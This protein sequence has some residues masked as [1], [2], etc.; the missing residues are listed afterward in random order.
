MIVIQVAALLC[1][2]IG[3]SEGARFAL[4]EGAKTTSA[5]FSSLT[6]RRCGLGL[7]LNVSDHGGAKELVDS[8]LE[9]RR[10]GCD[11]MPVS[12]KW[13]ELEPTPGRFELDKLKSDLKG[14]AQMG[15]TS[16]LL[17]KTI[18]TSQRTVPTDLANEP[19]DSPRMAEREAAFLRAVRN[20][21]PERVGGIMLGNEVDGYLG[22]RPLEV[23]RYI[24]FLENGRRTL[25]ADRPGLAVGVTTMFTGLKSHPDVIGRL[26]RPMDFVSMTYYPLAPD[27]GVLPTTDV[28]RHFDQMVRFAAAK[29]LF[30]QEAGYPA[31]E[32]LGSSEDKQASFVDAVFDAME[33]YRTGLIGVCFF[34]L[35]DFS[36]KLV[37]GFMAYYRLPNARF[38]AMLATLGLK[39]QDGTP[40]AAWATFQRRASPRSR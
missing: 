37:D 9:E 29:G 38:R 5:V 33:R 35:V 10:L 28:T 39:K 22:D 15:F 18:D 1:T 13:S 24:R 27:F 25:R 11:I 3:G 40:R 16:Y 36:D 34:L 20:V 8:I 26:H 14:Q 17:I 23:D 4:V 21:L 2:R 6:D 12:V 31:S 7:S 19:W 30:I 32:L